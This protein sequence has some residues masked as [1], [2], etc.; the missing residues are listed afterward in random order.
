MSIKSS[1]IN[2]G[3]IEHLYRSD[4]RIALI[5]MY[6]DLTHKGLK[7]SKDAIVD[8]YYNLES[9][10]QVFL[11][12]VDVPQ[13]TKVEFINIIENCIDNMEAMYFNDMLEAT[14]ATLNNIKAQGGLEEVANR[15]E[16]FL[17]GI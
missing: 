11:D 12:L 13:L 6:R 4:K 8:N 15:R 3:E 17:D 14:L 10:K 9:I 1:D 5:K 7:D 16:Q 2:L